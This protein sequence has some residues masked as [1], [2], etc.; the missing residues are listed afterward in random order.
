MYKRCCNSCSRQQSRVPAKAPTP[1]LSTGSKHQCKVGVGARQHR[2]STTARYPAKPCKTDFIRRGWRSPT[3][4][5][6]LNRELSS[7]ASATVEVQPS[8][9]RPRMS[10]VPAA[11][12][13]MIL[14]KPFG[15]EGLDGLS[16]QVLAPIFK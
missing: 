11:M 16:D 2:S 7:V 13:G 4:V 15:H 1:D 6:Y 5:T 12:G 10:E 14:A 9:H 8:A 3:I